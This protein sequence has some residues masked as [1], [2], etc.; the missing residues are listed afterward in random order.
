MGGG[1]GKERSLELLRCAQFW[2]AAESPRQW[3]H[4]AAMVL[5]SPVL[6]IVEELCA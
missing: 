4:L 2:G 1:A 6:F 3:R 5:V